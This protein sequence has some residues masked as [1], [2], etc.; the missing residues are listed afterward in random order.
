MTETG[1]EDNQQPP[2]EPK[3]CMPQPRALEPFWDFKASH[4]VTACLTAAIALVSLFQLYIYKRQATIM[5][6]QT[7]ISVAQFNLADAKERPWIDLQSI[8]PIGP[9]IFDGDGPHLTLSYKLK[10][11]GGLPAS[12]TRFIAVAIPIVSVGD[13]GPIVIADGRQQYAEGRELPLVPPASASVEKDMPILSADTRLL[14]TCTMAFYEADELEKKRLAERHAQGRVVAS[15]RGDIVFPGETVPGNYRI[16]GRTVVV[17]PPNIPP[18]ARS[19]YVLIAGC[20][21]YT[22]IQ[23]K[24]VLYTYSGYVLFRTDV[25]NPDVDYTFPLGQSNFTGLR[26]RAQNQYAQ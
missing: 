19:F 2:E 25:G 22:E 26:V 1:S 23:T 18:N 11:T 3:K 7:D 17:P 21:R 4:W 15:S 14:T 24:R 10:N 8:E 13:A 9:L 16:A 6:Q 12:D 5:Q 20:V